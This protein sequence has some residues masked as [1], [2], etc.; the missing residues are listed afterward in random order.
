MP[1]KILTIEFTDD[2][3][4]TIVVGTFKNGRID[5]GGALVRKPGRD[6]AGKAGWA[7][8]IAVALKNDPDDGCFDG[9]LEDCFL[10]M[11]ARLSGRTPTRRIDS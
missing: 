9:S 10:G 2:P 7:G 11:L 1:N 5:V 6:H 8:E 3:D 4:E